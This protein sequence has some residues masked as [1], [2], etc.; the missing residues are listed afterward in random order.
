MKILIVCSYR[1]YSV[2]TNFVAPFIYDQVISLEKKGCEVQ[3]LFVKGG[4]I[5]AYFRGYFNLIHTVKKWKPDIV[6]AHGGLC[7]FISNLQRLIPVVCTYHGSDINLRFNRYISQFSIYFSTYNIFVSQKLIDLA[8]PKKNYS[9]IPCGVDL[10]LFYPINDKKACRFK[11]NLNAEKKY[12]LFSKMFYDPVKNYPLAKQAIDKLLN[13]ELLEFVGYTREETCFLMNACDAVLMTSFSEGSP[14]FI[15]EAMACN[16]PIVSVDVG[17]VKNLINETKGCFIT[18]YDPTSVA[19]N[20]Q[21]ALE[22]KNKTN[23][24]IKILKFDN[25]KIT[26]YI[27]D[28][29]IAVINNLMK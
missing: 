14:Q 25:V 29:Y 15:K 5:T 20:L 28:I 2:H 18:T 16:C 6:H 3:Y 23:G 4:G 8:K 10:E 17:D 1:N 27:I 24:R 26:N 13:V 11:L 7:G 19:E 12:V 21:S 22:F 9:L